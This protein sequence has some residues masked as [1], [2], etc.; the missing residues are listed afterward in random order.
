VKYWHR[1]L[2]LSLF[3]A[4]ITPAVSQLSGFAVHDGDR[5]AFYGDSITAQRLYTE[6]VEEYVI[7][8]FPGWKVEFHNAGVGGDKVSGGYA[9]PVDLRLDR[10]V[11]AWHPNIVTV[12]LGMNDFYYRASEP[13]I[14]LTYTQGYQRLVES[15]KKNLPDA[16]ITLIEPSP[17]DDVTRAPDHGGL[18]NALVQYGAVVAQISR[19]KGTQLVD[20]NEPVTEFLQIMN[21]KSPDLAKQVVP[22]RVHPQP[23][24]HWIMAESLLK[25]WGAPPLVSSVIVNGSGKAP[26]VTAS[27]AKVEDVVKSKTGL[28][29]TETEGALPLP[30]PPP[31]LDPVLG[32]ALKYSDLVA[33]LDEETIAVQGL[34]GGKYDL[35]IDDE[36]LG[37]FTDQEL[38]AGL[39]LALINTPMLK[40]ARLV[41][42]DVQERNELEDARF[43][44][45]YPSLEGETSAT[46]AALASALVA[47]ESQVHEDAQ[48]QPHHFEIR[49]QNDAKP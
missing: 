47:A 30:F 25:A 45:I 6:D 46:A 2:L 3:A 9:G 23:G 40:Q 35:L 20:F 1:S 18:N 29:W 22:D 49:A 16:R 4:G 39:N 5:V 15:L 36:N 37:S 19:E 34:P 28:R 14:V 10:D 27:N 31:V 26:S 13:G 32:L 33:A 38:S 24:G 11:F 12:M 41:A 48:P 42:L 17:Y 43:N 8:R 7:T 21:E 44:V